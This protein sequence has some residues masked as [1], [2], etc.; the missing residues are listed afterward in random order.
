MKYIAT[1]GMGYNNRYQYQVNLIG[2]CMSSIHAY[3][4]I[5]DNNYP[6][7]TGPMQHACYSDM[8]F[9]IMTECFYFYRSGTS[10]TR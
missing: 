5:L 1:Y 4:G 10:F 3:H 7:E 8:M 2:Q 6:P 9:H